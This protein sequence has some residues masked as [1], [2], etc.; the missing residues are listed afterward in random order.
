[1]FGFLRRKKKR[2]DPADYV[3]DRRYSPHGSFLFEDGTFG[4][5]GDPEF[6]PD[7][8]LDEG[9]PYENLFLNGKEPI[10][11]LYIDRWDADGEFWQGGCFLYYEGETMRDYCDRNGEP[12]PVKWIPDEVIEAFENRDEKTLNELSKKVKELKEVRL[13]VVN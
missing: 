10:G 1:M 5:I 7:D 4:Y 8:I 9:E 13:I 2:E 6:D 11:N 12:Y 3:F